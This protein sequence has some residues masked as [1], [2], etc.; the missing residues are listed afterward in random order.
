MARNRKGHPYCDVTTIRQ[1][2]YFRSDDVRFQDGDA[3][4]IG[5]LWGGGRF[6]PTT[7]SFFQCLPSHR[8]MLSS[9][10]RIGLQFYHG[11]P[12]RATFGYFLCTMHVKFAWR[13]ATIRFN[14]V[15][16]CQLIL[17]PN[18]SGLLC[19]LLL[20]PGSRFASWMRANH[21]TTRASRNKFSN[22]GAIEV[23]LH[24]TQVPN[25]CR[26]WHNIYILVLIHS[27]LY[28]THTTLRWVVNVLSF[29]SNPMQI[30][31]WAVSNLTFVLLSFA[32]IYTL[33]DRSSVWML[34]LY[35]RR[36]VTLKRVNG[37]ATRAVCRRGQGPGLLAVITVSHA[38]DCMAMSNASKGSR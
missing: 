17:I 30:E 36:S 38:I 6:L 16:L 9:C 32:I 14:N 15:S 24:A 2:R 27:P 34:A 19:P 28:M 25:S 13:I 11:A 5:K 4:D 1:T 20:Y 3:V 18:M 29:P 35:S 10:A 33:N 23:G 31:V 21:Y 7:P 22:V 26:K 8:F 37:D 12:A